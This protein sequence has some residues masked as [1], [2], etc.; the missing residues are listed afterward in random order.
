M[1]SNIS[2]FRSLGKLR[3]KNNI[4][5]NRYMSNNNFKTN[6]IVATDSKWGISK[7]NNIPWN[8]K[9][10]SNFFADVTK[11]QYE[12][13]KL[14]VVIMG[15][16]TWK[17][18]P[19]AMRGLKDRINIVISSSMTEDELNIDNT[20]KTES[21]VVKSFNEG[22]KLC[23][24]L[25]PGKVFIGGGSSIYKE[26]IEKLN[27]DEIYLTKI[28]GDYGCDNKFPISS[29][30]FDIFSYNVY[31]TKTFNC[32]DQ[33]TKL[34]VEVTFSKFYK[35]E[36]P[37]HLNINKEEQQYLDLLENVIKTGHF[38]QTRNSKTW[39]KFGKTIEFDLNKGFPIL[40]TKK[41]FFR[42]VF[43]E[44]LFFL[45][46]DTNA[47]HLSDKGVK[48]W[49]ANTSREF[50]DSVG[51]NHYDPFTLGPMYGFNMKHFNAPYS[52]PN[53]D[54]TSCGFDQ[55][56]YCLDLLKKDPFSR[57]VLM[58][59]YNPSYASEG[60][61]FPC[62]GIAILFNVEPE[63]LN[64]K[65]EVYKLSCM[66]FQRSADNFCGVP[67]N[68]CSYSILIHLF[69]EIINN[70]ASYKGP[71]FIPGR[72]IMNLGD[73]HIY[74][75]HYAQCIRQILRDSHNFPQLIFKRK[76]TELT[77]FKFEDLELVNYE[78]YPNIIAKMVA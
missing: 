55:I 66:M 27:I 15:K 36:L 18:L 76:V 16:N 24:K 59:T 37:A 1:F 52:G 51:L 41:V 73:T 68:I 2:N 60:C 71:K 62:H 12:K 44:L 63:T 75:D 7:Q 65:D 34:P 54:Y 43:E 28:Q 74:E 57:R 26:A 39:T 33:N 14:N 48:I 9:E 22:I 50:L 38:R 45:K 47:K 61:L 64:S 10:D 21:Y 5:N 53:S 40:T 3:F 46:G 35:G 29:S 70:D 17:A 19:N 23:N 31:S 11:R 42:G 58:T 4:I 8:I 69:C 32:T 72:L 78:S 6:L 67:F 20:T 25:N 56:K 49:D 30:K 13:N 77:D